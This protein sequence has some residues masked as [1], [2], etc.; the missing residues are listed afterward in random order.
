MS[1]NPIQDDS[2]SGRRFSSTAAEEEKV[3]GTVLLKGSPTE[4]IADPPYVYG[5]ASDDAFTVSV[6]ALEAVRRKP[7][8]WLC[9]YEG[10]LWAVPGIITEKL[11]I[12]P[13]LH[14]DLIF[15]LCQDIS[16]DVAERWARRELTDLEETDLA[17]WLLRRFERGQ[18]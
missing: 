13:A 3:T 10:R 6:H 12:R 4:P 11:G 17:F 15:Y 18:V 8:L 2:Q 14:R 16:R 7:W 5:D 9:H 1:D